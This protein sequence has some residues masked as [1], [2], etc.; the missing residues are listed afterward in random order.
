M[1]VWLAVASTAAVADPLPARLD[2]AQA[3]AL[4]RVAGFDLL[5]AEADI[6]SARGD[7]VIARALPNPKLSL[8]YGR[9]FHTSCAHP[10]C[11]AV[12]PAYGATINDQAAIE[13]T[14]SGKRRLRLAVARAALSAARWERVDVE[15]ALVL[16]VKSG[17]VQVLIGQRTL[18]L[19]RETAW[20]YGVL[21]A[22]TERQATAGKIGE[23]DVLRVRVAKLQADQS[24][25][26]AVQALRKARAQ[27]AFLLGV[28][29]AVPAYVAVEPRLEHYEL[30]PRLAAT[31]HDALLELAFA[32]RPD[33]RALEAQLASAEAQV[34]VAR[35]ERF[36]DVE[37]TVGYS[38][39]GTNEL[40]VTPPTFAFG[41]SAPIP[42]FYQQQGEIKKAEANARSLRVQVAKRRA[43]IVDD[44]ETAYAD[45]VAAQALVRRME[46]GGLLAAAAAAKDAVIKAKDAGAATLLDVLVA[47]ATFNATRVEYETDVAAYW[48]AVF[49]LEA[50][51]GTELL[52]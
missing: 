6:E 51:T 50:A 27:L 32:K 30:P 12:P 10:P 4:F 44:F 21:L 43:V 26:T 17:F 8:T 37:V 25:D 3:I 45:F 48:T 52:R 2:L 41:L 38:Q 15:R 20:A 47:L 16:E 40:A 9:S 5:I 35:R 29:T 46:D 7:E 42:L 23:A 39:Q 49:E 18:E 14:L 34:R 28:R 13:S 33:L 11:S 22:K 19:A 1:V 36:P 31:T 24:V